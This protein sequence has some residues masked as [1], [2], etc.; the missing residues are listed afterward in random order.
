[1]G[2]ELGAL[3][4]AL[5][6]R[7]QDRRRLTDDVQQ[8]EHVIAGGV[9]ADTIHDELARRVRDWRTL[10]AR[11]VAQG[12]QILR[13]LLRGRVRFTPRD[14]G[15]VELSG[16]AD[17]GKLFSGIALATVVTSP[18]GFEPVFWP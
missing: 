8:L 1:V 12:R 2:G 3:V 17:Y 7:E 6:Q 11:N 16:Q 14:D 10:A 4:T 15:R 13:K 18:T 5:K 9:D